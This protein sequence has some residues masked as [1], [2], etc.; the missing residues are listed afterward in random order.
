MKKKVLSSSAILLAAI[1]WGFAFVAQAEGAKTLETFPYN[2]IRFFVPAVVLLIAFLIVTRK[3]VDKEKRKTSLKGGLIA[4]AFLFSAATLQQFGIQFS[5]DGNSMKAGFITGLYAITVPIVAFLIFKKRT[6]WNVWVSSGV[7]VVGLYLLCVSGAMSV[8]ASDILLLVSVLLWTG[9]ILTIDHFIGKSYLLLFSAVQYGLTGVVSL[10]FA[11]IFNPD[12]LFNVEL[13]SAGLGPLAYG[14][15]C[16]VLIGFTLQT[17]GQKHADPTVAAILASTES[18]FGAIGNF[19]VFDV[20][21]TPYQYVGCGL[22]FF[23]IIF[24][25]L[26]LDFRKQKA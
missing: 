19:I 14:A 15:I 21:F 22:I 13:L 2:G 4:G 26:N 24:S 10:I 3:G 9:H 17:V 8:S 23:G 20:K 11:L 18:L 7:A 1:L 25:Q 16:S 6:S 5:P 12:V